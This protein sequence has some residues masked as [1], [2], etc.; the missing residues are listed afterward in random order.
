[1]W[2]VIV[3]IDIETIGNPEAV[4]LMPAP[5]ANGRLKDP[6]KIAADIAE[7]VAAMSAEAALDA[8]TARVACYAAVGI[9]DGNQEHGHV[10]VASAATDNAERA[11]V[12]SI[13]RVLGA[14][15]CRIVTWNG[16]GF[17]LPMIY[18][19]A[20]LLGVDPGSF[21]APPLSAW[22]T[23]YKTD[24]HY[25]LM[26]IWGGWR[27]YVKLETV[28]RMVMGEHREEIEYALMPEL[29]KTEEGRKAIADGCLNH[30]RLTWQ[31]WQRFNGC[32]FQ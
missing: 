29:M 24:R 18:K 32:L 21:G 16:I 2:S 4:K 14:D 25:D 30:T 9:V 31:L 12:Q 10:E 1:M 27:D 3:A 17:D 8:L 19:R 6:A 28:A 11:I 23:R 5:K 20:M 26:Q 13:M 15:E 7:K 22:T